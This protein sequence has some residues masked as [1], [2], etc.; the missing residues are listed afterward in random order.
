MQTSVI[1][2][3]NFE[4]KKRNRKVLRIG[5]I[6]IMNIHDKKLDSKLYR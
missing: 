2:Y 6:A 3:Q 5:E 4:G 1:K